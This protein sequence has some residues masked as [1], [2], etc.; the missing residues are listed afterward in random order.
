MDKLIELDEIVTESSFLDSPIKNMD[1]DK[2]DLIKIKKNLKKIKITKFLASN[3][4]KFFLL[5]LSFIVNFK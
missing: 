3:F 2:E 1:F 5:T 4:V